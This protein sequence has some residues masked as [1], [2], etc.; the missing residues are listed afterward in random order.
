MN[1]QKRMAQL[2]GVSALAT[3]V[4]GTSLAGQITTE[5]SFLNS[6]DT[7][8]LF[9]RHNSAGTT[10]VVG[11]LRRFDTTHNQQTI[12]VSLLTGANNASSGIVIGLNGA[13]NAISGC[14]ASVVGPA[15]KDSNL[16]LCQS[17]AVYRTILT[18]GEN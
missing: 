11:T 4:S 5:R 9:A 15:P 2:V 7:V 10:K 13:G 17:V 18:F 3:L 12:Q 16:V 6:D 1:I 14:N 8:T